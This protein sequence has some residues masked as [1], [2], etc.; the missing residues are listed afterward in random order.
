MATII[1]NP[2]AGS[3]DDSG[4]MAGIIMVVLVVLVLGGLFFA[5]GLPAMQSGGVPTSGS[6]DVN[7]KLPE[8][9]TPPAPAAP[10]AV[11]PAPSPAP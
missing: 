10:A 4:G 2:G 6:I 11:A 9:V 5:Y 3:S 8:G 7:V 1:N